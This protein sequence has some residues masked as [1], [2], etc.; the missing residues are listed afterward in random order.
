MVS[1]FVYASYDSETDTPKPYLLNLTKDQ[2]KTFVRIP[3]ICFD[4]D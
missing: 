4:L 1:L 3:I 2:K